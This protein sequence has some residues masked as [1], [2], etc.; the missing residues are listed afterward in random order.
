MSLPRAEC[1]LDTTER[2]GTLG[3]KSPTNTIQSYHAEISVATKDFQL[4]FADWVL[5]SSEL[6]PPGAVMP[7]IARARITSG[8]QY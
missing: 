7:P 1:T 4:S 3:A 5:P 6:S 8:E 2:E